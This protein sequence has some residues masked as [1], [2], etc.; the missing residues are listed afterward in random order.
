MTAADARFDTPAR[1][2]ED[3][4]MPARAPKD[5]SGR[6]ARLL[7]AVFQPIG[8]EGRAALV[9]RRIAEAI[10][11]GVLHAGDRLPPEQDLAQTFGVAPTTVREA[12]LSL[13][14]R[15]LVVTRRGRGGGSFVA[16]GADPRVFA[17]KALLETTRVSLRDA[18]THYLAITRACVELAARRADPSEVELIRAR[19]H[20]AYDGDPRSWRRVLDDAQIELAALSQ[21]ARLTREQMKLQAELSPLFALADGEELVRRRRRD[22]LDAV[23]AAVSDGDPDTA[24][25]LVADAVAQDVTWLIAHR[26]AL[27]AQ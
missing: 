3:G 5:H 18:A 21:S 9:E 26:A 27:E 24:G 6:P 17:T 8:D 19:I 15:G 2:G 23:F 1:I 25:R 22:A 12:L 7:S 4:G 11:G 20:R 16:D 10:T 14:A 13:R